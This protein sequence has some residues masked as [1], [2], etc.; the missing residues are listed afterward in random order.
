M[1]WADIALSHPDS[2][3]LVPESM[4]ALA[5]GYEPDAAFGQWCQLLDA[6]QRTVWVCPGTSAWRSITAR[7][8]ER[9]A[10]LTAAARQG[11][12]GGAAGLLVTDWGDIGHRQQWP[13]TLHGLAEAANAAWNADAAESFYP[14]ASGLHAFGDATGQAGSWL[15]ALGDV[16]VELRRIA[17]PPDASGT[18]TPLRNAS[19]LFVDL[20]DPWNNTPTVPDIAKWRIVQDRLHDLA[21]RVPANV[22]QPVADELRHT[23]A[24]ARFA[25][26][27]AVARRIEGGAAPDER[28][29]LTQRLRQ[30]VG[31]HRRLWLQRS[32][33]GGLDD[34]CGHYERIE[35]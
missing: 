12:A 33:P 35:V 18:P 25:A 28:Q 24:V 20:H 30:I 7:T 9:R 11:A 3:E 15:D 22:S 26:D 31:E 32:R 2:I 4:I 5:W 17:G 23:L 27:R 8:S 10:N 14:R 29:H 1:F 13:I 34:S 6:P 19:A 21:G 16:D